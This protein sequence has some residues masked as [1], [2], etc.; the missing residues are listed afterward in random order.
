[1]KRSS[2]YT[3]GDCLAGSLVIAVLAILMLALSGVGGCTEKQLAPFRKGA[4]ATTRAT[5]NPVVQAGAAATGTS[6]YVAIVSGVANALL[7][8]LLM[9]E[10]KKPAK[11]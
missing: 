4:S 6:T 8:A 9:L 7:V 10:K 5:S 1:M 2:P 3:R 11:P